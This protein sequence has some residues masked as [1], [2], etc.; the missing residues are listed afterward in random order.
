MPGISSLGLYFSRVGRHFERR[1]FRGTAPERSV[2]PGAEPISDRDAE[3]CDA[4][5]DLKVEASCT[6]EVWTR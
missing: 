6:A 1:L 3:D 5:C 4:G 2:T